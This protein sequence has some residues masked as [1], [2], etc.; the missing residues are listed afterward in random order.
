M[1]NIPILILHG[2]NLSADKYQPL[3]QDLEN[4]GYKVYATDL[5]GFRKTTVLDKPY[6]IDDYGQFVLDYLEKEKVRRVLILGHSFGGRIGIYLA[7][8]FPEKVKGLILSGSP[9]LGEDLTIKEKIYLFLAKAGKIIFSIPIISVCGNLARK[10][11]YKLVGSYDYYN[12]KG[13][14]RETF[15]NIVAYRLEP[16]L[17]KINTPTILIWGQNDKIVTVKVAFGMNKLIK[18]SKLVI[19]DGAGH[20]VPWTHPK[21]FSDEVEKFLINL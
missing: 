13:T 2:W 19:I 12:A 16:L 4:K 3:K 21:E 17:N 8:N 10:F 14:F 11:L 9:G 5:P 20:G 18:N 15:K 7:V 1:K 6:T